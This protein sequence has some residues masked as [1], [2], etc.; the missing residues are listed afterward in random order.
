VRLTLGQVPIAD[1]SNEIPALQPLLRAL[2]SLE[3]SLITADA[4]HCQQESA[5]L[6]TQ[7]LGADYLFGS[8]GNP[9][10]VLERAE[11]LLAQQAFP[12]G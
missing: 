4:M 3:G 2:P 8:K 9:S 12:P 6:V 11:H 5:R 7:E 10:G 1:K